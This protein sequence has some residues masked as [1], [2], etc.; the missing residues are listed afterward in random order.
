MLELPSGEIDQSDWISAAPFADS[1]PRDVVAIMINGRAYDRATFSNLRLPRTSLR[2]TL[3]SNLYHPFSVKIADIKS[4]VIV[5]N[6][7]GWVGPTC[8]LGSRP[9]LLSDEVQVRILTA[10]VC[11]SESRPL[12]PSEDIRAK[13][14]LQ[15]AAPSSA[16][17]PNAPIE[18][19]ILKKT[20]FWG[21]VGLVAI[22][23]VVAYEKSQSQASVRPISREG[24]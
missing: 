4:E 18:I 14:G 15:G 21:V 10:R 7:T 2:V 12:D 22:G 20:W 8:Q 9:P 16:L 5:P 6:R 23:A 17:P 3:V 13:F 11:N 24:W 1:L 19:P